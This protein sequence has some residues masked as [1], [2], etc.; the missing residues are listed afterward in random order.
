MAVSVDLPE[1]PRPEV[2]G[3]ERRLRELEV[4]N[5][6]LLRLLRLTREEA[7]LPD[8]A[9]TALF[10]RAPGQV[11]ARSDPVTKVA[12]FRAMFGARTDVYAVRWENARSGRRLHR[13]R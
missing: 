9:Q 6:R 1:E 5:A 10:D 11:D 8:S 3:L 12:F 2:V 7:R 13:T 4:E